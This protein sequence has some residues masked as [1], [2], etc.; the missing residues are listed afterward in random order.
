M[1]PPGPNTV[2]VPRD[3]VEM[4]RVIYT[5]KMPPYNIGEEVTWPAPEARRAVIS[6]VAQPFGYPHEPFPTESGPTWSLSRTEEENRRSLNV[7][8]ETTKSDEDRLVEQ[9]RAEEVEIAQTEREVENEKE[10]G[11]P[12]DVSTPPD[13]RSFLSR[14]RSKKKTSRKRGSG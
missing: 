13:E 7:W 12:E 3:E 4:L 9:A 1:K 10:P 8:R 6:G 5:E 11:E 14:T 2:S